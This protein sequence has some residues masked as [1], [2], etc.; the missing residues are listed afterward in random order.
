MAE[1]GHDDGMSAADEALRTL[2]SEL[3]VAPSV[4]FEARVR[5]RIAPRRVRAPRW[6]W[7]LPLAAAALLAISVLVVMRGSERTGPTVASTAPPPVATRVPVVEPPAV[8]RHSAPR[9]PQR[10]APARPA[11]EPLV[12]EGEASRIARY[13]ASVRERPLQAEMLPDPREPLPDPAPIEITP[14]DTTP[15][16][17]DEGSLR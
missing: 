11:V 14:L 9:P 2:R 7:A 15:L 10:R 6:A 8:D 17:P 1:D 4:G 16:V 3:Q 12:P 13:A 5:E